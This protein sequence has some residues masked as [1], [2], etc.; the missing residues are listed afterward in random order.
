[1]KLHKQARRIASDG[2]AHGDPRHWLRA[3]R[4]GLREWRELS[5]HARLAL[6]EY[7]LSWPSRIELGQLCYRIG[8]DQHS[9]GDMK[10]TVEVL[11]ELER[12]NWHGTSGYEGAK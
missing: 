5:P 4:E 1:M 11:D 3:R 6:I 12:A 9:A 2:T 7:E 8:L 10:Y